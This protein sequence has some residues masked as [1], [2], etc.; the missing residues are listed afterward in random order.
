ML[1]FDWPSWVTAIGTAAGALVVAV[2]AII[3][4]VSL[5][6]AKRTRHAS[7]VTELDERWNDPLT[8]ASVKLYSKH[9][10]HGIIDLYER[11]YDPDARTLSDD[12]ITLY[13]DLA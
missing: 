10:P 2:A 5:N 4:L 12:D 7:L 6:D 3:A 1:A 8:I 9:G 13:H 11:L